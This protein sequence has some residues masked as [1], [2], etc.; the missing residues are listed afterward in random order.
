M[1]R[2][3]CSIILLLTFRGQGP[4]VLCSAAGRGLHTGFRLRP[5]P[6]G[7]RQW[8][9]LRP[10]AAH[11][12]SQRR[13]SLWPCI[14]QQQMTHLLP[15]VSAAV[16]HHT[17]L[18][19]LSRNVRITQDIR[20]IHGRAVI[21]SRLDAAFQTSIADARTASSVFWYNPYQWQSCWKG[22][23]SPS[24]G[25]ERTAH[26]WKKRKAPSLP[27]PAAPPH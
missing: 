25:R 17:G 14:P 26:S 18:G 7:K 5:Q 27:A 2:I 6:H 13:Q 23:C 10:P 8:H 4:L 20:I 16:W 19:R 9:A 12:P 21:F 1:M 22:A 24:C 15:G 11:R 3:P